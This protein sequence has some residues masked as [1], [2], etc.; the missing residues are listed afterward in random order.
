MHVPTCGTDTDG[1]GRVN[2]VDLA[3]VLIGIGTPP[4]APGTGGDTNGDGVVDTRDLGQVLTAF[5][6]GCR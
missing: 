4:E 6:S 3:A 2:T 5:G 1:D